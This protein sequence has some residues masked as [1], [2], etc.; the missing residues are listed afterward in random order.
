MVVM[1]LFWP[2][3]AMGLAL[4]KAVDLYSTIMDDFEADKADEE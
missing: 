2:M 3:L 1:A 4:E